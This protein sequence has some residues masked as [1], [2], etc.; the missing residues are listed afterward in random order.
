MEYIQK[1]AKDYKK[2]CD[3][4]MDSK[5]NSLNKSIDEMLTRLEEF[6]TMMS[7]VE[8]DRKDYND[9]LTS[10]P[11]YKDEFDILCNRIDTVDKLTTH[12]KSN[13][14]VLENEIEKAESSLGC[15]EKTAKVT[16][17]FTPLFKK[18][19]DKKQSTQSSELFK[20]EDYFD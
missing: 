17:I 4:D 6:Q 5:L 19:V 18:N 9:I 14:D 1:T 7:F 16:Q 13:L 12:I 3:V 20:T 11:N 2:C 8:Q 15:S 10:V